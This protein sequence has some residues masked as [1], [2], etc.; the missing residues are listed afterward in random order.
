MIVIVY[1]QVI[2]KIDEWIIFYG[3]VGGYGQNAESYAKDDLW[4]FLKQSAYEI[5]FIGI[6]SF[7]DLL[8]DFFLR[9]RRFKIKFKLNSGTIQ[10]EITLFTF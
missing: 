8:H 6:H 1:I 5:D 4:M 9:V 10:L 2:V 3:P 7:F